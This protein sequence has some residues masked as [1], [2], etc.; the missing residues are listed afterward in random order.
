MS[1]VMERK[2]PLLRLF[3]GPPMRTQWSFRNER[4]LTLQS[5]FQHFEE[6]EFFLLCY[7]DHFF[8]L[9]DILDSRRKES[10]SFDPHNCNSENKERKTLVAMLFMF[11]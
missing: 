11:K 1:F 6:V 5:G 8:C 7:I 3:V 10:L 2:I 4:V 9:V